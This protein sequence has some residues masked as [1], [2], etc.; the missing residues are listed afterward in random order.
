MWDPRVGEAV[1]DVGVF[2]RPQQSPQNKNPLA[3][4]VSVLGHPKLGSLIQQ[5]T[6]KGIPAELVPKDTSEAWS[7]DVLLHT[8]N[9][10]RGRR[11][12]KNEPN[13]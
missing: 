13:L 3:V 2:D 12:D 6:I 7:W 11:C 1:Q 4:M 9:S 8:Q 5:F 10:P